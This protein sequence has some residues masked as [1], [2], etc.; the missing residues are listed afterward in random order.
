MTRRTLPAA[1]ALLLLAAGC[2]NVEPRDGAYTCHVDSDCPSNYL[3]DPSSNSC[4]QRGHHPTGGADL[5]IGDMGGDDGGDS[6][7]CHDGVKN[8]NETDVD[9]GGSCAPCSTGQA[10]L[11]NQDCTSMLC[12]SFTSLCVG[13]KCDDGLRDGTETDVD[14]G[15]GACDPCAEGKGC[16]ANM[17]CATDICN[18]STGTCSSSLCADGVKDGQESDVDCGGPVCGHCLGGKNCDVN[19]DCL[20]GVCSTTHTCAASTCENGAKDPGETDVDC[21]GTMCP[22]CGLTKAC[23]SGSD[24]LTHFCNAVSLTCV[25]SQ[26]LDGTKNGT[27]TDVDCG[28]SCGNDC[29]VG[30]TCKSG[31]DCAS[32]TCGANNTCVAT[33][34][35]DGVKDGAETDK[36]CGGGTCPGCALNQGCAD[37]T[38]DCLSMFC[39]QMTRVCVADQCHD[40]AVDGSESDIDCG[41]PT[42]PHCSVNQGCKSGSDCTSTFC[43]RDTLKCV[44][45]QCQDG[46]KDNGETDVDCGGGATTGCP[47]CGLG[48]GCGTVDANCASNFCNYVTG[49]CVANA[50]SDGRVDGAETDVDCGGGTCSACDPGRICK[51]DGDCGSAACDWGPS[52]HK[53]ITDQCVDHHQDGSETDVD[54]GGGS[55]ATCAIGKTCAQGSDCASGYCDPSSHKCACGGVGQACCNGGACTQNSDLCTGTV[56]CSSSN[57]CVESNPVT[58]PPAQNSCQVAGTCQPSTGT[59]S[60]TQLLTGPTCNLANTDQ[61][62]VANSSSCANGQC[63]G[64]TQVPDRCLGNVAQTCSNNSWTTRMTCTNG[65]SGNGVCNGPPTPTLTATLDGSDVVLSWTAPASGVT[66]SL[67]RNDNLGAGWVAPAAIVSPCPASVAGPCN[68]Y[69][70]ALLRGSYNYALTCRDGSG[71]TSM[72][73]PVPATGSLSPSTELCVGDWSTAVEVH[74]AFPDTI[75]DKLERDISIAASLVSTTGVAYAP[76]SSASNTN[77][78]PGDHTCGTIFVASH[79]NDKIMAFDRRANDA[80]A[81]SS[82]T[83]PQPPAA[84]LRTLAIALKDSAVTKYSPIGVALLGNTLIVAMNQAPGF[85]AGYPT[86]YTNATSS[87]SWYLRGTAA[88]KNKLVSPLAVAVDSGSGTG[89]GWVFVSNAATGSNYTITGYKLDDITN[90]ANLNSSN[91]SNDVVAPFL[92]ITTTYKADGIA[93]DSASHTLYATAASAGAVINS[94]STQTGAFI[95][96]FQGSMFVAPMG[97]GFLPGPNGGTVYV[98]D[99]GS[100]VLSAYPGG[101]KGGPLT[102]LINLSIPSLKNNAAGVVICN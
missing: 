86:N 25:A 28:G 99:N 7:E 57:I 96:S 8:G 27:E 34:C 42:C 39:N 32:G 12:N 98:V 52:P 49:L 22:G 4:W 50:C 53:C 71:A 59:C 2:I 15:G 70:R 74:A 60:P 77:C 55:C 20:S 30:Q 72:S 92:T 36:D 10:C 62:I 78:A 63:V 16:K 79:D 58:C 23:L 84:S 88:A 19:S 67:V 31:G 17:D 90:P 89:S 69:D 61:C 29:K 82:P 35:M 97:V 94:Y 14:C 83:G 21:G 6:P 38:R 102:P 95:Q 65:C 76:P 47:T 41:G 26:C 93:I 56:S 101:S 81:S 87:P 13:T 37:G 45:S 100:G 11:T 54:C 46:F 51:V 64:G 9:C 33:Q 18:A 40:G 80:D 1:A 73:P 68:A 75:H 3:C 43:N 5:S 85:L 66:C 48:K 24:C 91:F 44:A